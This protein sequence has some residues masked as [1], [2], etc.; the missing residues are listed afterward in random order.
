MQ[1][2]IKTIWQ[3]ETAQQ[4][5]DALTDITDARTMQAFLRDVMTEK[6]I[7]E[8]SSRLEAARM[9]AN[10]TKYTD[11]VEKTKLSSTTVARISD[12]LKNGAGGY[13]T[14]LNKVKTH[15]TYVPPASAE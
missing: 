12:W 10:G 15:H 8:I 11:I 7:I 14:V 2:S 3:S 13:A 9:L 1:N 5:A 4:L 6:E